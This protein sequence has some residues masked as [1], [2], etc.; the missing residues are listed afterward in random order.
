MKSDRAKPVATDKFRSAV[1][2]GND[3]PSVV[4]PFAPTPRSTARLAELVSVL[5]R[6]IDSNTLLPRRVDKVTHALLSGAHSEPEALVDIARGPHGR[7]VGHAF[8]HAITGIGY[9]VIVLVGW[10]QP[11]ADAK[12]AIAFHR[13]QVMERLR[14]APVF[15]R[16]N[17]EVYAEASCGSAAVH[18][19]ALMI[20]RLDPAAA[21]SIGEADHRAEPDVRVLGVYWDFASL[22]DEGGGQ[23]PS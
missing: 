8:R 21:L 19:L 23:L 9:A 7:L 1:S 12:A 15:A 4:L 3:R 13:R 14:F 5:N 20:G 2:E 17:N 16:N 10:E 6:A 11:H 18:C 22:S